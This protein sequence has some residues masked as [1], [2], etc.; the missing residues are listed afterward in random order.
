M[1]E[2][3]GAI[4]YI[5]EERGLQNEESQRGHKEKVKKKNKNMRIVSCLFQLDQGPA[6]TLLASNANGTLKNGPIS[7]VGYFLPHSSSLASQLGHYS[8]LFPQNSHPLCLQDG[9]VSFVPEPWRR[10]KF[11]LAELSLQGQ[12]LSC[13]WALIHNQTLMNHAILLKSTVLKS[14]T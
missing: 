8:Q 13:I 2:L 14:T 12:K 3:S 5:E 1:P 11:S 4:D 6:L 7:V 10:G 9:K